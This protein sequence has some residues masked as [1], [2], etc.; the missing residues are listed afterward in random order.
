MKQASHLSDASVPLNTKVIYECLPNYYFDNQVPTF[1]LS[2]RSKSR[3]TRNKKNDSFRVQETPIL[4][5]IE[6]ECSSAN[7]E[8]AVPVSWPQCIEGK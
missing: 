5:T 2:Q 7:G 6:I 8:F 3:Y 4:R 1:Q